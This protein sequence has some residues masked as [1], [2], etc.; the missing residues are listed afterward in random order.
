MLSLNYY[1]VTFLKYCVPNH[2]SYY[3]ACFNLDTNV[4]YCIIV[5]YDSIEINVLNTCQLTQ[6]GT[7]LTR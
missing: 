1:L 4:R 2:T 3:I 5:L 6:S 7:I